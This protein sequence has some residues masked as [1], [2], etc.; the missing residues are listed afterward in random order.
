MERRLRLALV[1]VSVSVLAHWV[2]LDWMRTPQAGGLPSGQPLQVDLR[3]KQQ[4][5]DVSEPRRL[6]QVFAQ[7]SAQAP[8][9]ER[10]AVHSLVP[11]RSATNTPPRDDLA[12][13]RPRQA[14]Q[15]GQ[16]NAPEVSAEHGWRAL[17]DEEA[18]V[19]VR[20]RLA[21]WLAHEQLKLDTP[22]SLQLRRGSN[23]LPMVEVVGAAADTAQAQRL[24]ALLRQRLGQKDDF[25]PPE[26]PLPIEI[27]C[28]PN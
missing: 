23:G 28:L 20:L 21:R 1:G 4:T 3:P 26:V 13:E 9:D 14:A 8:D 2:V 16:G 19:M 27:E 11:A 6:P 10:Q 18:Q 25:L 24:V 7:K 22:V 15:A 5:E 12:S 17:T